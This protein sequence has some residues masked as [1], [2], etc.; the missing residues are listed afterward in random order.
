MPLQA[1]ASGWA[2]G[3][4]HAKQ[5]GMLQRQRSWLQPRSSQGPAWQVGSTTTT[6][7]SPH[8][9]QEQQTDDPAAAINAGNISSSLPAVVS[10]VGETLCSSL[11][12]YAGGQLGAYA[13][14]T[15]TAKPNAS[16]SRKR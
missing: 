12:A 14:P 6:S 3:A 5:D 10:R 13:K 9:G 4:P 16:N 11:G 15:Q 2:L 1:A 8:A 7:E